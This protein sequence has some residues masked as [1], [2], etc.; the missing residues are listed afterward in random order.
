MWFDIIMG[1]FLYAIFSFIIYA[2]IEEFCENPLWLGLI[3]MFW[4]IAIVC[5]IPYGL[6][7]L[8]INWIKSCIKYYREKRD[9][10]KN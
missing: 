3:V 10:G 6:V 2:L 9:G 7:M 4:P 1:T 5:A 8:F